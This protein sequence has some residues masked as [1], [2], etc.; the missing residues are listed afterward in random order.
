MKRHYRTSLVVV[1]LA[2]LF[3]LSGPDT[4][5]AKSGTSD[6]VR[7]GIVGSLFRDVPE[8]LVRALMQ[9]FATLMEAQTGLSGEL[10]PAGRADELARK[11]I[12]DK[13][14]IGVF[15]GIEFAWAQERYPELQPLMIVFTRDSHQQAFLIMRKQDARGGFA[16]LRGKTVALPKFSHEHCYQFM[17]KGCRQ[18]G[19]TP[20]KLFAKIVKP[21]SAEDALDDVADGT[22][23]AAILEKVPLECYQ[24][25]KP[26]RFAEMSVAAESPIFPASVIVC[27]RGALPDE[28]I[29]R[30][31]EGMLNGQ[32]T[33]VGRQLLM[34]W[35]VGGFE[36]IPAD[37]ESICKNIVKDYPPPWVTK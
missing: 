25:R 21:T 12:D 23:A 14:H 11:L 3:L 1:A 30:F 27:R 9:P 4:R 32:N 31:R 16:G 8:S 10:Y 18:L 28:V 33:P 26:G 24:R 20:D 2:S 6:A 36:L 22:V 34:L 35:R 13:V 15:Q 17:E 37:Y 19:Q 29:R 7:I 5:A